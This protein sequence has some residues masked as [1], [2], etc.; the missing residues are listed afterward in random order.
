MTRIAAQVTRT[1]FDA[2]SMPCGMP[3]RAYRQTSCLRPLGSQDLGI[4]GWAIGIPA[5]TTTI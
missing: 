2:S 4:N 1:S 3:E 5:K